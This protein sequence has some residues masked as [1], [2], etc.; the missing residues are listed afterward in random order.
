MTTPP[1]EI[2]FLAS[3]NKNRL[4]MTRGHVKL[5]LRYAYGAKVF[6]L[7]NGEWVEITETFG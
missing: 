7:V 4:Y 5:G 2:Y 1:T 6:Q 3:R